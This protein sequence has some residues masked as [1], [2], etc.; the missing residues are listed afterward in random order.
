MSRSARTNRAELLGVIPQVRQHT[1]ALLSSS[2]VIGCICGGEEIG[3]HGRDAVDDGRRAPL[4]R[5]QFD[6]E[7]ATEFFVGATPQRGERKL[8]FTGPEAKHRFTVRK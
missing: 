5:G 7:L 2:R 6:T 3:L 8:L 1:M 4:A